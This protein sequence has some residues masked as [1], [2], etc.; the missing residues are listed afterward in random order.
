MA[1]T[2][3]QIADLSKKITTLQ[4]Q[5]GD[6][7]GDVAELNMIMAPFFARYQKMIWPYYESLAKTQREIADIRVS[8]GDRSA[9]S[10]GEAR[11]PLDRFFEEMPISVQ[12]QYERAWQGKK[13]EKP[14][15]MQRVAAAP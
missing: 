11:S 14:E 7:C 15:G 9:I 12:E 5:M 6:L 8:M 13:T 3:Q 2:Q 1:D 4:A 10:A